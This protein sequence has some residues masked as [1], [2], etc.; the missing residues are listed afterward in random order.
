MGSLNLFTAPNQAAVA[1]SLADY[2]PGGKVFASKNKQGSSL[3]KLLL[4]LATELMRADSYINT[5]A[6]EH[7]PRTT[8]LLISEW[9]SAVGIPDSCF[10]NTVDLA[11]RQQQVVLKLSMAIQSAPSFI[12]LANALGYR[13]TIEPGAYHGSFTFVFPMTFYPNAKTAHFTMIVHL[14]SNLN[15]SLFNFTFPFTFGT[16]QGNIIEC[17]FNKLKPANVTVTY[18]YDL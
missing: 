12:A 18:V 3:N 6:S 8:Q 13:C 5:I 7:D 9:E 1:K 16:R 14:S 11:T 15:P 10:S 2:L 4:G 17:L